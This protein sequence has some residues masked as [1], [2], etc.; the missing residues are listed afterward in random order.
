MDHPLTF[1]EL[2]SA[3]GGRVRRRRDGALLARWLATA[4]PVHA[5]SSV[6]FLCHFG[7][8]CQSCVRCFLYTHFIS[9]CSCDT[10]AT[11]QSERTRHIE[12]S[13]WVRGSGV[14]RR[15]LATTLN[16]IDTL[17]ILLSPP[18]SYEELLNICIN[19]FPTLTTELKP[20]SRPPNF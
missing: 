4:I 9:A 3:A 16:T 14:A 8:C 12:P 2:K 1:E 5:M 20:M 6:Y 7:T 15:R 17:F 11:R 19:T 13:V 10:R 18:A